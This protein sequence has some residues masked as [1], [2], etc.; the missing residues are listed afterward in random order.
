[1]IKF[2]SR[3][4]YDASVQSM[5]TASNVTPKSAFEYVIQKPAESDYVLP[6]PC[7]CGCQECSAATLPGP[8]M[9]S[10]MLPVQ[11]D[12][13]RRSAAA[14][15]ARE[16][17]KQKF[18][19][20]I[21][22]LKTLKVK[23]LDKFQQTKQFAQDQ[24]S[25]I[26]S[27]IGPMLSK[28][29]EF[30]QGFIKNFEKPVVPRVRR[31]VGETSYTQPMMPTLKVVDNPQPCCPVI[32]DLKQNSEFSSRI[33][34]PDVLQYMPEV[35]VNANDAANQNC[36]PQCGNQLSESMCKTC[37]TC[38]QEPAQPQYFRYVDGAPV[39]FV[40]GNAQSPSK[41]SPQADFYVY[42]RF[43]HKYEENNGNLR[44]ITPEYYADPETAQPNIEVFADIIHANAEVMHDVNPF[45]DGK[46]S[47]P[48]SDFASDALDFVHDLSR[49][50]AKHQQEYATE[51][52]TEPPK[53]PENTMSHYQIIPIRHE[54]RNGSL[55]AKLQ[56]KG[57]RNKNELRESIKKPVSTD[58]KDASG[59]SF[60]LQ[61]INQNN[62]DFEILTIDTLQ[63]ADSGE[64]F[65]RIMKYLHAA[66]MK[67]NA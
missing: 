16:R 22:T 40:P 1:M 24:V 28:P 34:H 4:T 12:R 58:K 15:E 21:E 36:C 50:E 52:K 37:L 67:R 66:R 54:S 23:T 49:R 14:E 25:K 59:K 57:D 41:R 19:G 35:G 18:N 63:S 43:G 2:N 9:P 62:N 60:T 8:Q 44:L 42:D 56:S 31:S 48:L 45:P 17:L 26:R 33:A 10:L 5:P 20:H 27:S 13:F 46:M 11:Y 51:L 30:V 38:M 47:G 55:I 6:V 65:D 29:T 64:E 3:N 53:V 39:S 61:K 32:Q 7:N